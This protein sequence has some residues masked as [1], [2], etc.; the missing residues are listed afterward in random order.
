[1]CAK[2]RIVNS[3]LLITCINSHSTQE[4]LN[5]ELASL[6]FSGSPESCWLIGMPYKPESSHLR[7][8]YCFDSAL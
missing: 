8:E 4:A 7:Y 3:E 2:C 1:M 5:S 6:I